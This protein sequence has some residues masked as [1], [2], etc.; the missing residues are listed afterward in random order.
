[1]NLSAPLHPAADR[2]RPHHGRAVRRRRHRLHAAAG[3]RASERR[4]PDA[5][6]ER[7]IAR[8]RPED[9]GLRRGATARAAV[10]RNPRRQPDHLVERAGRDQHHLA[11]RPVAQH[12]RRRH[13]R[14]PGDQR[15][16]RLPAQEPA[17]AADLQEGQSRRP[18]GADPRP[19]LAGDAAHAARPVR[20]SRRRPAHLDAARR[21]PGG[22]LRRAEVRADDPDQPAFA[23]FARHRARRH[24]HRGHK[25]DSK[26]ARRHSAGAEPVPTRSARTAS[27]SCPSRSRRRS[28][29]IATAHRCGSAT[30]PR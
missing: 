26:P 15:C 14:H 18:A 5:V 12:R 16:A 3:R 22:D 28:S 4:F 29:P 23:R 1:M 8:R 30:S 9:D 25:C 21:R 7:A 6:G 11:I 13:R 17:D 20:R 24:R 27:C 19:D 10:R 2:H